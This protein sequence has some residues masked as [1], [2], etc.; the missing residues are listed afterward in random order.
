LTQAF[1]VLHKGR[2][3]AERYAPGVTKDTQ[4]ENWSM[5]KSVTATLFALL[6]KDGVYK[7]DEPAPGPA[8]AAARRSARRDYESHL[9]QMSGGLK[10]VGNQE[11]GGS[12]QKHGARSLLHLHGR[13]RRV[14][15]LD[16]ASR[17]VSRRHRRPLP[18]LRSADDRYLIKR[19]VEARGENYLTFPQRRLFDRIGIRR[20]VLETDPYGNFLLTGYDYGTARNWARIGQSVSQR[21]RLAGAAASAGRLDQVREHP[22]ACLETA[23]YGG[24]FWL[25][26]TGSGTCRAKPT[27]RPAP[28]GRTP[29][30]FPPTTSSSSAWATCAAQAPPD[31]EPTRR[32]RW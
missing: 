24:F 3:I 18:Q 22:R 10:F 7:I 12:P 20:Q 26:G 1:L 4:L 21:R 19:A 5:G 15:F 6:V 16:H 17:G 25:N 13:H 9:L 8:V 28:A 2:I 30:S 29:G 32:W 31:A 23:E 27:W 14:Q 11:P